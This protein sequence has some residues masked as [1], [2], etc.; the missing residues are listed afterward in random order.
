MDNFDLTQFG[1]CG[2]DV[3]VSPLVSFVR[4][5]LV[6]LGSHVAIDPFVHCSTALETGDHV[7]VSAHVGIIGGKDGVLRMGH[8]TNISVGGRIICG[9]DAFLGEGLVAAPGIPEAF[10]DRLIVEPV[11]FEDFVNTGANVTIFPG[12]RLAEGTVIGAGSVVMESTEPWTVYVGTPAR[13]LKVRPKERM[14]EC[15]RRMGYR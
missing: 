7:H 5:R 2:E 6:K 3:F 15:A 1:G 11:T 9:S 14:L 4:P 12:V 13:P 10:R 8:F